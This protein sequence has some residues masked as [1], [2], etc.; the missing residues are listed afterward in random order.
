MHKSKV[1]FNLMDALVLLVL[2]VVVAALLY[3]FVWSEQY[4]VD[5]LTGTESVHVSYVVEI[6]GLYEDYQDKISVGDKPIDSSKKT[7]LG[8]ITALETR[9]YMYTGSNLHD[10]TM[11]LSTVEDYVN[12]YVT[13]EADAVLD[14]YGYTVNGGDIYVGKLVYLAFADI[15]CSGYCIALDVES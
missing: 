11:V 13:I 9:P 14:G 7:A 1:K 4:S 5:A 6:T 12:M 3:I 8:V 10:G 2:V 15:V